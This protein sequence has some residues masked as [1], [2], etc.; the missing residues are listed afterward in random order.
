MLEQRVAG[1][2]VDVRDI[3]AAVGRIEA[4]AATMLAELRELKSKDV[5]DLRTKLSFVEG[6]LHGMPNTWQLLTIVLTTWA[7]GAAIVFT[8]L[9]FLTA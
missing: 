9:R 1:L 7:A 5:A 4:S 2:E 8:L 6:R 3:K